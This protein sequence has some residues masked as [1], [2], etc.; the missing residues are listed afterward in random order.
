MKVGTDI[1]LYLNARFRKPRHR[2]RSREDERKW[3]LTSR[4]ILHSAPGKANNIDS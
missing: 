4:R 2:F 3:G 1:H